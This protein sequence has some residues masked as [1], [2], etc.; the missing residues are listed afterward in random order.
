MAGTQRVRVACAG[1]GRHERRREGTCR[2]E[3]TCGRVAASLVLALASTAAVAQTPDRVVSTSGVPHTDIGDC[4]ASPYW[5]AGMPRGANASWRTYLETSA[6]QITA[7]A[8]LVLHT[9]DMVE[10]RWGQDVDGAGVFGPVGTYRQRTAAVQLAGDIYY[11][12]YR[13]Y[14]IGLDVPWGQCDHEVGDLMADGA[15]T[16]HLPV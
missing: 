10:G 12:V 9:G 3:A 14:W 1:L 8:D 4:R 15:P 13:R 7:G 6:G 2:G 5:R 16:R 11:R